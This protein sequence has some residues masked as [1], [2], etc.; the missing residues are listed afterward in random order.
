M[1]M[2]IFPI[3]TISINDTFQTSHAANLSFDYSGKY[4][5]IHPEVSE[6][7]E[8]RRHSLPFNT[9]KGFLKAMGECQ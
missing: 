4:C 5:D 7:A 3:A 2:A 8:G 6:W 1:N 9:Q